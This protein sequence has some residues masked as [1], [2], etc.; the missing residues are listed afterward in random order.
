MIRL[1]VV[2]AG[3]ALVLTACAGETPAKPVAP[4]DLVGARNAA[5][6]YVQVTYAVGPDVVETWQEAQVITSVPAGWVEYEYTAPPWIVTVAGPADV[7]SDEDHYDV[8]VTSPD[9]G[10][11]WE[12]R[13]GSEGNVIEGPEPVL[14]AC[15]LACA[16]VAG[17]FPHLGLES[18]EW[19]GR[20]LGADGLVGSE[21]YEYRAN[22]W[23]LTV[24]YPVVAPD[25]VVY[26]ITLENEDTG[27]VWQGD[28]DA[29]HDLTQT[30]AFSRVP[31]AST[32]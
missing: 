13:V 14:H 27:F 30:A 1:V 3:I 11:R 12:G 31:D 26:A 9:R 21:T 20:R 32:H 4:P 29:A 2:I 28:M 5:L 19:N 23:V 16:Y 15:D 18:L 24:S 7:G 6:D 10:F 25:A 17:E 22:G 8:V